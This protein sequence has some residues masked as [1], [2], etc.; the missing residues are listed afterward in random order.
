MRIA[1]SI[2]LIP[3]MLALISLSGCRNTP[4]HGAPDQS[5]Q[6]LSMTH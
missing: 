4:P 3:L 2:M 6:H 1:K 5:N